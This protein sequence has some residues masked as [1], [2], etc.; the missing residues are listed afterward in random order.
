[1]LFVKGIEESVVI[2]SPVIIDM[3]DNLRLLRVYKL[4]DK[5]TPSLGQS[6]FAIFMEQ[7]PIGLLTMNSPTPN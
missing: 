2:T 1:V 7:M 3:N 4:I 5:S 6:C